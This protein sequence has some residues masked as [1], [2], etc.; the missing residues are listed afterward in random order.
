MFELYKNEIKRLKFW[1][2]IPAFV[3]LLLNFSSI[4]FGE[5]KDSGLMIG[6]F[7]S[8][9]F[10]IVSVLMGLVQFHAYKKDNRWVYLINRP[11][12]LSSLCLSLIAAAATIVLFQFVIVD[13][14][15]TLTPFF[16]LTS[17]N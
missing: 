5:Y 6:N 14:L 1:I 16:M 12:S 10:A 2:F 15:I 17:Y 11:I 9:L 4:Y 13:L 8:V 3:Y 7:H